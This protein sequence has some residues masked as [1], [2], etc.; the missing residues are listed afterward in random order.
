MSTWAKARA[1]RLAHQVP[2]EFEGE[3][4]GHEE[5]GAGLE[6]H[7]TIYPNVTIV[8]VTQGGARRN[9][10]EGDIMSDTQ[11]LDRGDEE[12]EGNTHDGQQIHP[13]RVEGGTLPR[14]VVRVDRDCRGQEM[15]S[16]EE[17]FPYSLLFV[18]QTMYWEVD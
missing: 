2:D 15:V 11:G 1:A 4:E 5:N 13:R 6:H 7:V 12:S 16:G 14:P 18:D 3:E 10:V 9:T 8:G 17:A